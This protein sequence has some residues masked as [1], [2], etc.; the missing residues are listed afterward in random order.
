MKN[1]PD[2]VLVLMVAF[3]VGVLVTLLLPM[4][5]NDTA[6]APASELQAGVIVGN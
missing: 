5:A 4:A 2:F 1:K 6:A 3:G